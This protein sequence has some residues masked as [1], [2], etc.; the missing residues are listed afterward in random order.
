[1]STDELEKLKSFAATHLPGR[2]FTQPKSLQRFATD[3]GM[4]GIPPY[5]AYAVRGEEDLSALVRYAAAENLP[6]IPRAGGSNTGGNAIGHGVVLL[7]DK[8][9]GLSGIEEPFPADG[10]LLVRAGASVRHDRLQAYLE[11]RG[12]YLPSDPSSGPLSYLGGNVATKAS[13]P[14]ALRH[15]AIDRYI[16]GIRYVAADGRV[17]DTDALPATETRL[18]AELRRELE[19]L[20][21]ARRFLEDRRDMKSATGYT[22][23]P[24]LDEPDPGVALAK[25]FA[26][27]L[28]TLGFVTQ[29]TLATERLVGE[30]SGLLLH[31]S[32]L[33]D[34]AEFAR[35]A[36]RFGPSAIE[37]LNRSCL[38][39]AASRDPDLDIPQ[40]SMSMLILEFEGPGRV[41]AA[42][43][44]AQHAT[45]A[46]HSYAAEDN[47]ELEALW[48]VRKRMLL[49]LPSFKPGHAAP[50]LVNDI[51]VPVRH[52][53]AFIADAEAVFAKHGILAPIYGHAGDGNLHLRP[54]VDMSRPDLSTL[55]DEVA[56]AI[57]KLVLHYEGTITGEHGVGRQRARYLSHEL[58]QELYSFMKRIK[59]AFDPQ[60]ICNPESLFESQQ[61]TEHLNV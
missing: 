21:E 26:G 57:Y 16:R 32:S 23:T 11:E 51:G 22:V 39:I 8:A 15:G 44:A 4:Y 41:E 17:I 38:E 45:T 6:L 9:E 25:L 24:L 46:I 10:H 35:T 58:P 52:L 7:F 2:L 56:T 31:F 29:V 61:I 5:A 42:R 59:S 36:L 60:G 34:A 53:A 30:K 28:G 50:A 48:L 43:S 47:N 54:L 33:W 40:E 55:L 19:H 3:M 13:G 37:I 14:H 1:M 20:P 49:E 12:R 18:I 27:S